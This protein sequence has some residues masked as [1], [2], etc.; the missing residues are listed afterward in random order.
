MTFMHVSSQLLRLVLQLRLQ[1]VKGKCLLLDGVVELYDLLSLLAD[2]LAPFLGKRFEILDVCLGLFELALEV[3]LG[4]LQLFDGLVLLLV[5]TSES[6]AFSL[7]N[8]ELG[9]EGG[10][11]SG[12][13]NDLGGFSLETSLGGSEISR[14]LVKLLLHLG[15]GSSLVFKLRN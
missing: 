3:V 11:A 15:L 14:R 6:I 12:E 9:F 10:D 1:I 13:I 4:L 2:C 7:L 8:F 5:L